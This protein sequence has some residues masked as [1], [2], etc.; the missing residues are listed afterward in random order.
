LIE[1]M[2]KK[3][4][5]EML[6]DDIEILIPERSRRKRHELWPAANAGAPARRINVMQILGMLTRDER[7]AGGEDNRELDIMKKELIFSDFGDEKSK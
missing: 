6:S 3:L 5:R 7:E 4:R 1:V 2:L